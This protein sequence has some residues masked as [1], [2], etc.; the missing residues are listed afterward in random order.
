MTFMEARAEPFPTLEPVRLEFAAVMFVDLDHFT[1]MCVDEPLD[2]VFRLVKNFHLMVAAS[3]SRFRGR[4]SSRLGDGA[5]VIFNDLGGG[6]S[7]CATRALKCAQAI[8]ERVDELSARHIDAGGRSVSLSIGLQYG[9]IFSGT[10]CNSK[11]FGP[12]IIGDAVN[13]ANR[14][15]QRG[16]ELRTKLVVGDDLVRRARH[17]ARPDIRQLA[18]LVH[19]GPIFLN[20]KA[21]PVDVWVLQSDRM[22]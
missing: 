1:G 8:L 2:L 10:I 22:K 14:L 5:M 6:Q 21:R 19:V 11:R 12:M 15:E 13:V 9:A 20:G 16:H 18:R 3:V 17:E 4:L 7:D